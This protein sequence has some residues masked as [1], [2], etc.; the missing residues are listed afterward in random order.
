MI[1]FNEIDPY[2]GYNIW[3]MAFNKCIKNEGGYSDGHFWYGSPIKCI[4]RWIECISTK[5]LVDIIDTKIA[6][7]N[8]MRASDY[9]KKVYDNEKFKPKWYSFVKHVLYL[10][11][12]GQVQQV[13]T[14]TQQRKEMI[15]SEGRKNTKDPNKID[16]DWAMDYLY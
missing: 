3:T 6:D 12:N 5:P 10:L 1:P 13:A 4:I 16:E 8:G 2:T 15:L 9:F 14:M 11:E 7:G